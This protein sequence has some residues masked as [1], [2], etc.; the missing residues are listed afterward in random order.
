[1]IRRTRLWLVLP[2]LCLVSGPLSAQKTQQLGKI[3]GQIRIA[4]ADFPPRQIMVELQLRGATVTSEYADMQGRFGFY[5]L[6]PNAYHVIVND[7][8][9]Y[10]VEEVATVNPDV[11][12]LVM[13]Q[14]VLQA[15]ENKKKD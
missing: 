10:R 11:S 8:A 12:P 9:Y 6:Q 2:L 13:V 5:G 1:M 14:I 15:R 7:E 4:T 3:V